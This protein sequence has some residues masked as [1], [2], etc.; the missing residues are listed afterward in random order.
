VVRNATG[1]RG[2]ITSRRLAC[3]KDQGWVNINTLCL[4]ADT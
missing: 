3:S 1:G 4:I 2:E